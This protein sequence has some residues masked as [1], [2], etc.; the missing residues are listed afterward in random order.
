MHDFP[1]LAPRSKSR[2]SLV[3]I[4]A[5]ALLTSLSSSVAL[6]RFDETTDHSD[7]RRAP[8]PTAQMERLK[9]S[10]TFIVFDWDDNIFRLP[11]WNVLFA[12]G[13]FG[14]VAN[15]RTFY[16][17]STEFSQFR[18]GFGKPG[19]P[20]A[21]FEIIGDSID[22]I[23]GTFQFSRPGKNGH[24]FMLEDMARSVSPEGTVLDKV[25]EQYKAPFYE[26]FIERESKPETR[27]ANRILTGRGQTKAEFVEAL[28]LLAKVP[29][30]R[31][32]GFRAID[33]ERLTLVGGL[34]AAHELK[35]VDLVDRMNEAAAKGYKLFAF[36]DDDPMNIRRAAEALA[37][38]KR[39]I[40]VWL[41]W[42]REHGP[43]RI[44][45]LTKIGRGLL[46]KS[47]TVRERLDGLLV[48]ALENTPSLKDRVRFEIER[49]KLN[50]RALFF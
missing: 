47:E 9:Q 46:G 49:S 18:D 2:L 34:G 28:E 11:S 1:V 24:N 41:I 36:P 40:P 29:E 42:T 6:A 32:M 27:V 43:A 45:D 35:A 30:V 44:V 4:S 48:E 5:T 21:P 8:L 17:S 38:V 39:P 25:P 26:L 23:N 50:C 10:S 15:P 3:L 33:A 7:V 19:T 31:E 14:K 12:K 16:I 37:S 13:Q 22:P 20:M